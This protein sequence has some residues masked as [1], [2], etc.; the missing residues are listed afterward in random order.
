VCAELQL[1]LSLA[2]ERLSARSG[3]LAPSLEDAGVAHSFRHPLAIGTAQ[4]ARPALLELQAFGAAQIEATNAAC[5][6]AGHAGGQTEL[7]QAL[8]ELLDSEAAP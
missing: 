6:A 8:R 4:N 3:G 2:R 1:L 7:H 5:I